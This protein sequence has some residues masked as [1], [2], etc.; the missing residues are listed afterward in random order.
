MQY[1]IIFAFVKRLSSIKTSTSGLCTFRAIPSE[2]Q[3]EK[4]RDK[5]WGKASV[6]VKCHIKF[7]VLNVR[8]AGRVQVPE[9]EKIN[10]VH[11]RLENEEARST[12]FDN[13]SCDQLLSLPW[14]TQKQEQK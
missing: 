3:N 1:F 14:L 13:C 7:N 8:A 2:E 10:N 4:R 6:A 5:C 12:E 9:K 11:S